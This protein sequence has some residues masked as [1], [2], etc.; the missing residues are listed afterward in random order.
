MVL[1]L[2][3]RCNAF[4]CSKAFNPD[5]TT[6][7]P[8]K[9][10]KTKTKRYLDL[11]KNHEGQL[12]DRDGRIKTMNAEMASLKHQLANSQQE[13]SHVPILN[14]LVSSLQAA[15]KHAKWTIADNKGRYDREYLRLNCRIADEAAKALGWKV[16]HH[17]ATR[18]LYRTF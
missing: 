4:R 5:P 6:P 1:I 9:T 17:H 2:G 12:K 18:K 8:P 7:K 14:C 13:A 15:L 11:K 10:S 3:A 16:G